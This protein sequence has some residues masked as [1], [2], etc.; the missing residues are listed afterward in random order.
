MKG[1]QSTPGK[2]S[3]EA[4]LGQSSPAVSRSLP[5]RM[6][7]EIAL[8]TP[9]QL[10]AWGYLWRLLLA[11]DGQSGERPARESEGREA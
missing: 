9:A 5:C 7:L 8:G 1:S 10:Q 4:P 6:Y 11:V 2:K 3:P